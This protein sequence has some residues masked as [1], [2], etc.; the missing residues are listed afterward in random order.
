MNQVERYCSSEQLLEIMR[1]KKAFI[2][3]MDGVIYHGNKLLE[4]VVDFVEWLQSEH[5]QYLFLTNSSERSQMELHLKLRRLGLEVDVS[6]FYTSALATA[7]FLDSQISHGTAYVIGEAG[8]INALYEAGY[9]MNDI[10]PDYVVVGESRTYNYDTVIKAANLVTKGAR[11][12][13][14]NPDLTGPSEYGIVPATGALILPIAR[15][16][17]V[18]PYFV[19][20]PNPVMM[21]Q[22]LKRLNSTREDTAIIGDR[23]DTD[24]VSGIESSIDTVLVLSG[25]SDMSTP[26][27]FAY[28][29]RL[30]VDSVKTLVPNGGK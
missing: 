29:P 4:G 15:T 11:L 6:H 16:A 9:T 19:G 8:L 2:C 10:N 26:N 3:D 24:I 22:A 1:N 13:G 7:G 23:M 21:R 27:R 14:T 25:V 5:K 12:I 17:G 30:I 18:E 20:K 28:R